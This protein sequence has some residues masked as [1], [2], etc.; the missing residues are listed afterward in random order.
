[1]Q[2][3]LAPKKK[4]KIKGSFGDKR[5]ERMGEEDS[6]NKRHTHISLP[7]SKFIKRDKSYHEFI[8][9]NKSH[10]VTIFTLRRVSQS[11]AHRRLYASRPNAKAAD[12]G[13]PYPIDH[14]TYSAKAR[15]INILYMMDTTEKVCQ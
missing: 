7:N 6:L 3:D 4:K 2:F 14:L 12:R 10:L 1:M 5:D 13:C 8:V 15:E 9:L 11:I